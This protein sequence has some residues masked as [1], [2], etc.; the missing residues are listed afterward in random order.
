VS[1]NKI[2][3]IRQ[4]SHSTNNAESGSGF[5]DK[6]IIPVTGLVNGFGIA[7]RGEVLYVSDPN[8]HII[9]KIY[10]GQASRIFA[11]ATGLTGTADGQGS[12]ARFNTPQAICLDAAGFLWVVDTGNHLIRKISENGNVYTVAST[13]G[14]TPAGIAVDEAGNIFL[15]DVGE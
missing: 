4:I 2:I 3:K 7:C 11:G 8:Q 6:V 5:P 12:S 9:F 14:I 13:S 15:V 1:D 10:R